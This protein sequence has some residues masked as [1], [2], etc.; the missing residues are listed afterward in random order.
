[1]AGTLISFRIPEDWENEIISNYLEGG[2]SLSL[3]VKRIL[4]ERIGKVNSSDNRVMTD[5]DKQILLT[6]RDKVE[7]MDRRL[8]K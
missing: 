4:G 1:M 7:E 8:K 6:L 3:F 2:E 5:D